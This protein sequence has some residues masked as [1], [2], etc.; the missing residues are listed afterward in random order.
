VRERE[1]KHGEGERES[2]VGG[3][4]CSREG[5]RRKGNFF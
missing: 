3:E 5:G 1:R 4:R 2:T